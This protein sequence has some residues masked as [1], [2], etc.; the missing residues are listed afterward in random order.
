MTENRFTP[1]DLVV[2]NKGAMAYGITRTGTEWT[3]LEYTYKNKILVGRPTPGLLEAFARGGISEAHKIASEIYGVLDCN[4][5]L[6]IQDN[7]N[8]IDR[9]F[10]FSILE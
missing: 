4:F 3:V 5:N 9:L 6:V 10:S 2:G 7:E 8:F 1:G